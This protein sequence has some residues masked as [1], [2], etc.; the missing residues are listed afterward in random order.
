M[1]PLEIVL[2][3]HNAKKR[4]E[5]ETLLRP[6]GID[7]KSL[8]DFDQPMDVVEDGA[9]FAE[10]AAK[11]ATS[12]SLHLKRFVI[13]E[14]SGLCV[15]ALHGAPGIYSARYAG[16]HATDEQNNTHLLHQLA[17]VVGRARSAYYVCHMALSNPQGQIVIRCEATCRGVLRTEP[18]GTHGFGYDPLFELLEYRKTFGELGPAVKS[19]LSH[20]AR[21]MRRF[22]PQLRRLMMSRAV[23]PTT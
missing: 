5:L 19:I 22:R 6:D 2:G 4:E 16:E 14:D 8:A 17:G 23:A 7:V 3:T 20:R 9:T 15:D 1:S 12:Q 13:G 18:A 11:K 21:A 10:N